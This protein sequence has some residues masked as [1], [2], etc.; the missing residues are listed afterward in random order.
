[1][2]LEPESNIHKAFF[3]TPSHLLGA[4]KN[5][6]ILVT[7]A[8][9]LGPNARDRM[10]PGPLSRSTFV[11]CFKAESRPE[12]DGAGQIRRQYHGLDSWLCAFLS[13]FYG[14]RF[15]AHGLFESSGLFAI[16]DMSAHGLPSDPWL[17]FNTH[18]PRIDV[19][20]PLNLVEIR[21]MEPLILSN[22]F[23]ADSLKPGFTAACRFYLQALQLVGTDP[24]VA[25]LHLITAGEVLSNLLEFNKKLRGIKKRYVRTFVQLMD[26]AYFNRSQT[27]DLFARFKKDD[28]EESMSAA[29]RLRSLYVH[30]GAPFSFW[31]RPAGRLWER[32]VGRPVTEPDQSLGD[33]IEKAPTFLG[34]ERVT[35]YCLLKFAES[36]DWIDLQNLE[37]TPA[38]AQNHEEKP[39]E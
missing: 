18:E 4:Y 8:W 17:P 30:T 32:Q 38:N 6:D 22:R 2:P 13:V 27:K 28:F 25:Y 37:A 24:E 31:V 23:E 34:L 1:M 12:E 11:F 33:T 15:D 9:P 16:P 35:R 26:E 19:P 39:A 21:R 36:H 14:K 29:Y 3:S 20:V 5:D 10:L 7:H